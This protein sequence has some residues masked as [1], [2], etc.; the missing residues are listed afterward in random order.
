MID[1]AFLGWSGKKGASMTIAS[2]ALCEGIAKEIVKV[3]GKGEDPIIF[4]NPNAVESDRA[5]ELLKAH[6]GIR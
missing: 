4:Y 2:A 3:R 6:R 5:Y 1:D